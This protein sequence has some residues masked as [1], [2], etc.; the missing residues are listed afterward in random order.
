MS[1][2][3][4][5]QPLVFVSVLT[6]GRDE[7]KHEI[8]DIAVLNQ[9]DEVLFSTAV[10][11]DHIHTADPAFLE[12][13]GYVDADWAPSPA[14]IEIGLELFEALSGPLIVG[15]DIPFAM[16]FLEPVIRAALE[17]QELPVSVIEEKMNEIQSPWID[18]VTL[19]WEQ[20]MENGVT[21]FSLEET[22]AFMRIDLPTPVSALHEARTI[23]KVYRKLFQLNW[24][25]RLWWRLN[26][27]K[28]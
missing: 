21:G 4:S 19:V 12:R 28:S 13:A 3:P 7:T 20:L 27:N 9:R 22:A 17:A 14:P 26:G 16:R 2:T 23:R 25:D 5:D 11:P 6:T 18:T 8:L 10:A 1:P 24:W 15:H